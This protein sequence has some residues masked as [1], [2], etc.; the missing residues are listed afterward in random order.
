MRKTHVLEI[1]A[2]AKALGLAFNQ[3]QEQEVRDAP[4]CVYVYSDCVSALEYFAR[5]RRSLGQLSRLP[6]GEE[7]VGPGVM[8]ANHL[9]ERDVGVEL[10]YV[11]GHA[12]VDGNAKA[13]WAARKGAG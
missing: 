3:S 6:Y 12:G 4:T 5:L 7:L 13:H 10:R 2:I 9:V 1:Y 11:P 8:A